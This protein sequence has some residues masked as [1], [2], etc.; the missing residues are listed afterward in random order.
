MT[1]EPASTL[2]GAVTSAVAYAARAKLVAPSALFLLATGAER[3]ATGL[4]G[5]ERVPL[6]T[7]D[8]VPGRWKALH[9]LVCQVNETT[10]WCIEDAPEVLEGAADPAW[11]RAFPVW[12][13]AACGA[14]VLIHSSAGTS[15]HESATAGLAHVT[16]HIN[17]SGSTPLEGLG[18][19]RLGPLFPDQTRV[20]DERLAALALEV[21]EASGD[22]L[23]GAVAACVHG[24]SVSTPAE[25]RWQRA[26]GA[27][28]SV[29][30][31]AGPLVAAAHA[32]LPTLALCAVT[33]AIDGGRDLAA[34]VEATVTQAPSLDRLL[35]GI[36][37]ELH[38]L[39][40]R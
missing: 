19:S 4:D 36:A 26:A 10:V 34:L 7:V 35:C 33:D 16:D 39:D 20:H 24:P 27:D 15:L 5:L 23:T 13:A 25:L 40:T 18:E 12:W 38:R 21:A 2:D 28:L 3:F 17:L 29:Q 30:D 22:R 32:G 31:L 1:E 37:R 11:A 6:A 14:E 8:G 9:L